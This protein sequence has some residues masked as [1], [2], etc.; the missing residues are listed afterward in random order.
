[1]C[2]KEAKGNVSLY[3][4][5][6]AS[7]ILICQDCDEKLVFSN[8][9]MYFLPQ[10]KSFYSKHKMLSWFWS[11]KKVMLCFAVA[12][13]IFKQNCDVLYTSAAEVRNVIYD[14]SFQIG[15]YLIHFWNWRNRGAYKFISQV[16][17]FEVPPKNT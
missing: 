8:V 16:G 14:N 9:N 17:E 10:D 12:A 1:M 15:K 3:F 11:L 13:V 5:W 4:E 7:K 6:I 2:S